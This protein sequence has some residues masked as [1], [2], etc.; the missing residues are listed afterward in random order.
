MRKKHILLIY[1]NYSP[2]K[3]LFVLVIGLNNSMVKRIYEAK[4]KTHVD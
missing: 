1:L 3:K 2:L 4:K